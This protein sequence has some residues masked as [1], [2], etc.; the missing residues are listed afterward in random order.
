M[1]T[2]SKALDLPYTQASEFFTYINKFLINV[3][4]NFSEFKE[5]YWLAELNNR[6]VICYF[7]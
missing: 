6:K 5:L 4:N 7:F 3:T 2:Y 1:P